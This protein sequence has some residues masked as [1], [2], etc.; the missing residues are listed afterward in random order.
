MFLLPPDTLT[1]N[2]N[3]F[4]TTFRRN[5]ELLGYFPCQNTDDIWCSYYS[6]L[7]KDEVNRVVPVFYVPDMAFDSEDPG[8]PETPA[9]FF[10][11]CDDGHLGLKFANK[12]EA[13]AWIK[14][15]PYVDFNQL[16]RAYCDGK[17]HLYFHN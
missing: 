5:S 11:G 16:Y 7:A 4:Y 10:Q 1:D 2:I 9:L 15:C 6:V 3:T 13:L 8:S 14:N 12:E 17:Q